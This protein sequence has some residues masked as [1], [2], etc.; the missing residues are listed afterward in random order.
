MNFK[1][2]Q[3]VTGFNPSSQ[4]HGTAFALFGTQTVFRKQDHEEK[5]S[6]KEERGK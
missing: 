4:K 2:C 5:I 1:L 3:T 6:P